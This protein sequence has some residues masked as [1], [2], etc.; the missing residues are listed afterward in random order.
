MSQYWDVG[1]LGVE[2]LGYQSSGLSEYWDMGVL[3]SHNAILGCRGTGIQ[4]YCNV[5]VLGCHMVLGCLS[6]EL[7]EYWNV[8]Y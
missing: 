5:R 8:G 3:G 4:W 6:T 7:F 1:V 2:V